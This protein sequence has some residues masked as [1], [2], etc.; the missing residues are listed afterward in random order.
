MTLPQ[1]HPCLLSV[2]S[3]HILCARDQE[4]PPPLRGVSRD[5]KST[6]EARIEV[7]RARPPVEC[8]ELRE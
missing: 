6:E 7:V 4:E 2:Q 1:V 3:C 5:S 8:A